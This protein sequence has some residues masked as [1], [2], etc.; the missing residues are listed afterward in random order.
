M[1]D[2]RIFLTGTAALAFSATKASAEDW[3][4]KYPEITFAVIPAENGSG[5]RIAGSGRGGPAYVLSGA[6]PRR[7]ACDRRLDLNAPPSR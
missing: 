6:A 4:A 1:I 3:K 7:S 2:R 5:M